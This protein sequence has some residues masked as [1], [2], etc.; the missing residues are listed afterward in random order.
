MVAATFNKLA[1]IYLDTNKTMIDRRL[2]IGKFIKP[3]TGARYESSEPSRFMSSDLD[4][5]YAHFCFTS[6]MVCQ[7]VN[8]CYRPNKRR[9]ITFPGRNVVA[10]FLML[11]TI[12]FMAV[13]VWPMNNCSTAISG[14]NAALRL[15]LP[16]RHRATKNYDN[17]MDRNATLLPTLLAPLRLE[18]GF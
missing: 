3:R 12:L 6:P 2:P 17:S 4:D 18:H 5:H 9:Q 1:C 16:A 11:L 8:F 10:P 7:R 13:A 15:R 14:R